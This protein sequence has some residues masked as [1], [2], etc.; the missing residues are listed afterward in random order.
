MVV[1][2]VCETQEELSVPDSMEDKTKL[3]HQMQKENQE[4]R[5]QLARLQHKFVTAQQTAAASPSVITL[6]SDRTPGSSAPLANPTMVG[7]NQVQQSLPIATVTVT[8]P[9]FTPPVILPSVAKH[10][11]KTPGLHS[12]LSEQEFPER[13]T[14]ERTIRDL[15]RTIQLLE[16][17]A[18]RAKQDS[19]S[20]EEKLSASMAALEKAHILEL[21]H[22]DELIHKLYQRSSPL[23]DS[24]KTVPGC[25]PSIST[26]STSGPSIPILPETHRVTTKSIFSVP[27]ADSEP[28]LRTQL[29]ETKNQE[30]VM[31]QELFISRSVPPV[32]PAA[33]PSQ[34]EKMM[35]PTTTTCPSGQT[36]ARHGITS[37]LP[38]IWPVTQSEALMT[39]GS[40]PIGTKRMTT[41]TAKGV[42]PQ[43]PVRNNNTL[44][45]FC[46][47]SKP[48]VAY[49][50]AKPV[51]AA[52][53]AKVVPG[54]KNSTRKRSFWD[55]T[56]MNSPPAAP[57]TRAS[58]RLSTAAANYA[59]SLLLQ[60]SG[61]ICLSLLFIYCV[62]CEDC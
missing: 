52:S 47:P 28:A 25:S 53:P 15:Q 44:P 41:T 18:E 14:A 17:E 2:Q 8:S 59:P 50:P 58:R 7:G 40:N 23:S 33:A 61:S 1:L 3:L 22:K 30:V 51:V 49:S 10:S 24:R 46:S 20:R 11:Q 57:V 48:V 19:Q 43:Y 62:L 39:R 42:L 21:K 31:K 34:R 9:P 54:C 32:A 55:I 37:V 16:M 4:L 5:I 6:G 38:T 56:N 26:N 13:V 29:P 60:V 45:R 36:L 35:T 12:S 27:P